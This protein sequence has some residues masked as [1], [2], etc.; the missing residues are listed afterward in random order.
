MY[1]FIEQTFFYTLNRKIIGNIGFLAIFFALAL[2]M[3]FP[4]DGAGVTWWALLLI[5]SSAFIFTIL[6]LMHLIVRPVNALVDT[7][8][9]SNR[10]GADLSQ[11]LPA[12][13]FDEFRTLS[14]EFNRFVSQL[15]EVL[16]EVHQQASNTH[17][18]NEQVSGAVK[19][20]RTN[21]QDTEKRSQQIRRESDEVLEH[22][23]DIVLNSDEMG[24]VTVKA[25]DKA[26]LASGQMQQLNRQLAAIA[27]LLDSFGSTINGLHK[28]SENVRQILVMVENFSDQTNLLALNAAI[29]AARAGDAGRGFA[30][31]ADE[32]R[33]LAAKVNDATKQISGFLNDMERLVNETRSESDSLNQQAKQA[34][35]QIS[36][37]S[38]EFSLLQTELQ[39]TKGGM[40]NINNTVLDLEKRY[41]QTHQ[42][43]S[44]IEQITN[45]AYQQMASIDEA[46]RNLLQ[47]TASTQAQLQRFA[48]K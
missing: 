14:D 13:T 34:Q 4:A 11:R 47:G 48:R 20:T 33:T 40:Y 7:L 10:K 42:H 30:V 38:E 12:F 2:Y 8:H 29:E 19:S 32:V 31:V 25:V 5:G 24:K 18:I 21:L 15:S 45:E 6:Y 36:Q 44:A 46:A 16:V 9:Q 22:L 17:H 41:Q 3:A 1:R 35:Q 28:N 39:A 23:A 26:Q 43:L 27:K 37:T